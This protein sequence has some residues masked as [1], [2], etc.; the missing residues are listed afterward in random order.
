LQEVER[1]DK[2]QVQ[3]GYD[4]RHKGREG[5]DE[6]REQEKKG[7]CGRESERGRVDPAHRCSGTQR[8]PRLFE[9]P[10]E[11]PE[12]HDRDGRLGALPR[13]FEHECDRRRLEEGEL[14]ERV[15]RVEA[16]GDEGRREGDEGRVES[17]EER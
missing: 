16:G 13:A 6:E 3:S 2:G 7:G 14:G 8:T 12:L 17:G 15:E 4:R 5:E 1:T 9:L 11:Q 10:P